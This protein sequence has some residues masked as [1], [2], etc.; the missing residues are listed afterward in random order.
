MICRPGTNGRPDHNS[1]HALGNDVG[2]PSGSGH[3]PRPF[4]LTERC[5]SVRIRQRV[6]F[7]AEDKRLYDY[8][9]CA[10]YSYLS[11]KSFFPWVALRIEK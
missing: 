6:A 3:I 4:A 7:G 9:T 1:A 11:T 8:I 10:P 5:L 2:A